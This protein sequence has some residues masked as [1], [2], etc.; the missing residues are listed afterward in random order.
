LFIYCT[1]H[2]DGTVVGSLQPIREVIRNAGAYVAVV[3]VWIAN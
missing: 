3:A 2:S 1:I